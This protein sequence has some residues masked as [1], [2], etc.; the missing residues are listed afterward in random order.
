MADNRYRNLE[1]QLDKIWRHVN[2]GS[3][4]TRYRYKEAV[5]RF[6]HFAADTYKLQKVTNIKDKHL[7]SYVAHMQQKGLSASTIK[8]ELSAIRFLCD[9]AGVKATLPTNVAIG[10]RLGA[11]LMQRTFGQIPRAWSMP[12]VTAAIDLAHLQGKE[13]LAQI[14]SFG[15]TLGLRIHE[16]ISLEKSDLMAALHQGYLHLRT[17]KGGLERDVPVTPAARAAILQTLQH[18]ASGKVFV[19]PTH[20]AHTVIKQ[21]QNWINQYRGDFTQGERILTYHGLRHAYAQERY[22]YH[23]I[24]CAHNEK[25]ARLH[26]AR[27]LGHGRDTVTR[28][29]LAGQGK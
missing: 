26:V 14:L 19:Q 13:P 9:Q 22:A 17:A 15:H 7:I 2:Q 29:Y 16:T 4:K 24:R 1:Q 27:E 6:C 3:I 23:L 21:V 12:E 8:T 25:E 18:C 20:K 28:I 10:D 11:P 5:T